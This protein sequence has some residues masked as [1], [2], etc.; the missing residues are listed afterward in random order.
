[1][2]L[3]AIRLFRLCYFL[4]LS[5]SSF[6]FFAY[7]LP[8]PSLRSFL[9]CSSIARTHVYIHSHAIYTRSL[10]F[11]FSLSLS[12]SLAFLCISLLFRLIVTEKY[13][14]ENFRAAVRKSRSSLLLLFFSSY[15]LILRD[16]RTKRTFISYS[17]FFFLFCSCP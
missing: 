7:T 6:L 15:S 5:L 17:S 13:A 10:F 9:L 2:H 4:S 16:E 8:D 3:F 12:L 1:M 14:V 11:P